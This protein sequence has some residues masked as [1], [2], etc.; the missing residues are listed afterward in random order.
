MSQFPIS[1]YDRPSYALS[2]LLEGDIGAAGRSLLAPET[3]SP[4]ELKRMSDRITGGE[5]TNPII[6]T[7]LDVSTNPLFVL[8]VLAAVAFPVANATK[9]AEWKK[10]LEVTYAKHGPLFQAMRPPRQ[11]F[12]GTKIWD[13]MK[14]LVTYSAAPDL[15][16]KKA[17]AQAEKQF[18]DLEGRAPE[19]RDWVRAAA[20]AAGLDSR[21]G[22]DFKGMKQAK[23]DVSEPILYNI[24]MSRGDQVLHN[25]IRDTVEHTFGL[26]RAEV[27]KDPQAMGRL[28]KAMKDQAFIVAEDT[29]LGK[30]EKHYWPRKAFVPKQRGLSALES[31]VA[32]KPAEFADRIAAGT[33]RVAS[34]HEAARKGGVTMIPD[35]EGLKQYMPESINQG[36]VDK[37]EAFLATHRGKVK[38][39]IRGLAASR[40][41]AGSDWIKKTRTAIQ[42]QGYDWRT[43]DGVVRQLQGHLKTGGIEG[44]MAWVDTWLDKRGNVPVYSLDISVLPSYVKSMAAETAW[45]IKGYGKALD[46]EAQKLKIASPERYH[47]LREVYY[48][49]I[50]GQRTHTQA[51]QALQWGNLVLT[52]GEWFKKPE[53]RKVIGEKTAAW[54][55]KQL[56]KPTAMS[57]TGVGGEVAGYFYLSALGG[58]LA[59][60]MKNLMQTPITTAALIGGGPWLSGIMRTIKGM[61]EFAKAKT[62][63]KQTNYEAMQTAF[64]EFMETF[65]GQ[66]AP[67]SEAMRHGGVGGELATGKVH[68]SPGKYGKTIESFKKFMLSFFEASERA[69]WLISFYGGREY[70]KRGGITTEAG[71]NAQGFQV[72]HDTQFAPGP[73]GMPPGMVNIPTPLRQFTYF[74]ARY[75]SFLT[76]PKGMGGGLGMVG[77]VGIASILAASAFRNLVGTDMEQGLAFGA[78]PLPTFEG[79]PFYPWPV[80]PPLV[81]VVGSAVQALATGDASR[82]GSAA[83][84]LVPGGVAGRRT[85]RTLLPRYLDYDHPDEEGKYAVFNDDGQQISRLSSAQVLMK[86][87]GLN[88][89]DVA[90]ERSMTQWLLKNR[91]EI[92]GY[93]RKYVEAVYQNDYAEAESVQEE[94]S[95]RYPE[96][97]K[98]EVKKSDF[99]ALENRRQMTRIDRIMRGLPAAYRPQFQQYASVALGQGITSDLE[100][101]QDT[102]TYAQ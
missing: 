17:L 54:M 97:G 77:R 82:L 18:K 101:G 80:V 24:Q 1:T 74:P 61:G 57:E 8:S 58:N 70:A 75:L 43:A 65:Q 66:I 100:N 99:Q 14:D 3:L 29:P 85:L 62:S 21:Q 34:G 91:D 63:G 102:S 53:V 98:I 71:M 45:T 44:A 32:E 16:L 38:E 79:A 52:A 41:M 9:L 64:P 11:L 42:Q 35:P 23:I 36:T 48:P 87:F 6:Q 94:F 76:T 13:T 89:V 37:L 50:R 47:Y 96:L 93:R 25:T 12:A 95:G 28:V 20:K 33:L 46:A 72:V 55:T 2:N 26:N 51:V 31:I 90:A 84:L 86:A 39:R 92:R 59:P 4:K 78:M 67:V 19:T 81:G 5:K 22:R 15:R 40:G 88:P 30:W 69:N 83:A 10:G 49:L 73:L 7:L 60:A 56:T 27:A 68:L